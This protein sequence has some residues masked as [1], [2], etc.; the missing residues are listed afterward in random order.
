MAA[1]VFVDANVLV[2]ADDVRDARKQAVARDWVAALWRKGCGA[3]SI[4]VLSE[5]YVVVTRHLRPPLARDKAIGIVGE[6]EA[7]APTATDEEL[8]A[9]AWALEDRLNYTFWDCLII[10]AA[11][12]ER[13]TH[14]LTEDLQHGRTIDGLTIISPFQ[15]PP[16]AVLSQ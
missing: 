6:F 12:R 9:A 13:C 10:A 15:I 1:R 14:F 2:Y 7:W 4:Q 3:T 8:L 5:F 16:Q 11:Q